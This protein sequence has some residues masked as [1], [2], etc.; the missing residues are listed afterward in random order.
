MLVFLASASSATLNAAHRAADVLAHLLLRNGLG[1]A[2]AWGC[3]I[4]T[5]GRILLHLVKT[6]LLGTNLLARTLTLLPVCG[7]FTRLLHRKNNLALNIQPTDLLKPGLNLFNGVFVDAWRYRCL[8]LVFCELNSR[9]LRYRNL[10]RL[11]FSYRNIYFGYLYLGLL[12]FRYLHFRHFHYRSFHWLRLLLNRSFLLLNQ[13]LLHFCSRL[14]LFLLLLFGAGFQVFYPAQYHQTRQFILAWCFFNRQNRSFHYSHNRY[15]LRL[16]NNCCLNRWCRRNNYRF[17]FLFNF[18]LARQGTVQGLQARRWNRLVF[19][20]LLLDLAGLLADC[21]ILS[22][23][24]KQ[25]LV[26]LIAD[27]RGG[28]VF[29]LKTF[30]LEM[31]HQVGSADIQLCGNFV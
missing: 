2:V 24:G 1:L 4:T 5:S 6:Y 7:R 14:L 21:L 3:R 18:F 15:R 27:F 16:R 11:L 19:V 10:C 26:H 29:H 17:G 12:R 28:L 9:N 23:L 31:S 30:F 13:W 25:H 20:L 22:E 8:N